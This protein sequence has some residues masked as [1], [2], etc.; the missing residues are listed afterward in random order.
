VPPGQ[1]GTLEALEAEDEYPVYSC[2]G[3]P[4]VGGL[5]PMASRVPG[6]AEVI[7]AGARLVMQSHDDTPSSPAAPDETELH[8]ETTDEQPSLSVRSRPLAHFDIDIPAGEAEVVQ[9]RDFVERSREPVTL[10]GVGA[11]M[12]V[13]GESIRLDLVR[14]NGESTC[15][16][17]IPKWDVN[18][19]QQYAFGPEAHERVQPGDT[20]RLRCAND[21]SPEN[22]A[23]VN[24]ARLE[25]RRV[26]WGEGTTDEM[27]LSYITTLEPYGGVVAQRGGFDTCRMLCEAPIGLE[28]VLTCGQSD[29]ACALC[30]LPQIFGKGGCARTRCLKTQAPAGAC[31][32]SCISEAET[33]IGPIS[34]CLV[35]DCPAECAALCVCMDAAIE[36][37]AFDAGL[38]VCD[39]ER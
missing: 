24:G 38:S 13:L 3:G 27:C 37:G 33:T 31:V 14:A 10:I 22:Q 32:R 15:P 19:Q 34:D 36:A 7:P 5:G 28:C 6:T 30:I 21:T 12:H 16:V 25:P 35:R 8:L 17:E 9:E 23:V 26:T 4:G 29:A 2:Y 39:I 1:L 18:W 20:C 11:L